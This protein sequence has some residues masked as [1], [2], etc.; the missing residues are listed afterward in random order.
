MTFCLSLSRTAGYTWRV[1]GWATRGG[2]L[3]SA[4]ERTLRHPSVLSLSL[5]RRIYT[6]CDMDRLTPSPNDSPRSQI[7]PGAR[8]AMAGSFLQD[9]FVSNYAKA[10]FHPGAGAGPGPG[11]DRSVPH[12]NGLLSP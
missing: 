11:T 2:L 10:R 7:V 3:F 4:P 12:T 9:Q 1:W 5:P 8:Y 6:G